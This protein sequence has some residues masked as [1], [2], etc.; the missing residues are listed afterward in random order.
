MA[1][2]F[3][4][5]RETTAEEFRRVTEV[6]YLGFVNGTLSAL[7]RMLPRDAGTVIQVG[8]ALAYR[9]IPL[10]AAYCASKSATRGFTDSLRCELVHDKSR[11]H[12]TMVQMPAL[13]TPQFRWSRSKMPRQAQPVPPIFQ[14]EVGARA[15]YHASTHRRREWWVGLPTVEAIVGQKF[16]PGLLDWYLGRTGYDAQQTERTPPRRPA[17]QS[18][19]T[20]ARRPW[21]AWGFR[22]P[23]HGAQPGGLGVRTPQPAARAGG[24]GVGSGG[25]HVVGE[26]RTVVRRGVS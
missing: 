24:G 13:N 11:V 9:S 2:V 22:R 26:K 7:K 5:I 12:V 15:V 3:A 10:Q 6:T 16:I 4:P 21:R 23:R 17:R 18:L 14:P 20:P 19:R 8:S 1:T 25:R